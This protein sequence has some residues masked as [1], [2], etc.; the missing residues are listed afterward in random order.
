MLTHNYRSVQGTAE[1]F[2][3]ASG[4]NTVE[5]WDEERDTMQDGANLRSALLNATGDFEFGID[6]ADSAKEWEHSATF[7]TLPCP[8]PVSD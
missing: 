3:S 2:G 1:P 7:D 6:A 5:S 4:T 8:P